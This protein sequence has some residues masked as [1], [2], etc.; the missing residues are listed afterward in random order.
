M[1]NSR[2]QRSAAVF[3]MTA[4][5]GSASAQ[6]VF[7]EIVVT[8]TKRESTLQEIP[9]AVTVTDAETIDKAQILD[10]A[11]LQTVVPSLRISTLQTSGN[12]NFIIRGFGNGANNPG[13]E[14]S[15][16]VFIDGVYRSRSA[17]AIS[18]LP[19]LERVEVLRGPQSTLFG[20]NASAGVISVI[21]AKPDYEFGGSAELIIGNYGQVVA[22][23]GVTGPLSDKVAFSLHGGVNQRDGYFDNLVTGN[24]LGER[25]RWSVRGQLLV[26]PT[27]NV[28]LRFIADF[29]TMDESCCG[30]A[31]LFN[32]PTGAAVQFIGGQLVPNDA[33]AYEAFYDFDPSNDIENGGISMQADIDFE[34]FSLVSITAYRDQSRTENAD[35]DFTSAALVSQNLREDNI[36]T[37]TQEFRIDS[38]AGENV[39][40]MLG[41]FFFSE[42]VKF[43]NALFYGPAMRAYTDTLV[44]GGISTLEASLGL[45]PGLLFQAGQGTVD[46]AGQD[47][48]TWSLFGQVDWH[49]S[50]RATLTLGANYTDVQKDA[51][52]STLNTDVFSSLDLVQIGFAGLFSA[53][54]G[55]QAPTPA[56]FA[57][58]PLQFQQAQALSVVP[59]S[60]TNAPLCNSALALQPLQ[61]IPPFVAFPNSVEDGSSSDSDTTWTVR[62][63]YDLTDTV[64]IY[65]SAA[66]GFKATSWNLSRDSLPF[67]EDL[68]AIQAAGLAVPNLVAGTRFAGPEEATVYELGLK[69][70][71]DTGAVNV[72]VFDQKI[73][74]F[75]SNIFTGTGFNLA[76]AGEQSTIGIELDATWVPTDAWSL[77]VAATW[78]DPEYDSFPGGN[79]VNGPTDLSGTE[80]P[81]IHELSATFAATYY[82][83]FANGWTGFVRGD[84]LFESNVQVIEN[85]PY[86]VAQREVGLLNASFGIETT[87]GLQVTLWGRNLTDDE[88]LLSAFPSVAQPGSYSGYPNQPRTYG[89]SLKKYFD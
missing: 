89:I 88:Y 69:A 6:A 53:L 66:T 10:I 87:N 74:G 62:L 83:D 54:T 30:V 60:P 14:P 36:E 78:L 39:D 27:D 37:F 81:G 13:I 84:Y 20:K 42:D 38:T 16:G 52:A 85:V 50:D 8:A 32:G 61:F 71:F 15:V 55:G 56:N 34:N 5:A 59:C 11:D 17:A 72:A 23:G 68:A 79:G 26:E 48:T 70:K 4:I 22:R 45:P 24:E 7:E 51:F 75:Q 63:A 65:A 82:M 19:N 40:W 3:L 1:L 35:V 64:N 58:F 86:N 21:T 41:A 76:N 31:N 2:V 49:L 25:D 46:T 28:S 73:E 33:F 12:T 29:D 77:S 18:D 47:D 44:M 43:D 80:P 67:A 9:V 57:A